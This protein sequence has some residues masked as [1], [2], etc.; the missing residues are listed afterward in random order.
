MVTYQ[1][2]KSL[3]AQNGSMLGTFDLGNLDFA[4]I[5]TIPMLAKRK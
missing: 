5:L 3:I 4:T 2:R 1:L